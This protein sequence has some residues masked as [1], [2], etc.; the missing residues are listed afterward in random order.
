MT[1]NQCFTGVP[2]DDATGKDT[3]YCNLPAKQTD[4][5]SQSLIQFSANLATT[6]YETLGMANIIWWHE[7][8]PPPNKLTAFYIAACALFNLS[9]SKDRCVTPQQYQV[10]KQQV[11]N[12]VHVGGVNA[13]IIIPSKN[14]T[15]S[16]LLQ[17]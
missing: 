12:S 8:E 7:A 4:A 16:L 11:N 9:L 5:G 2:I 6:G 13:D 17:N 1:C 15:D 3:E 14:H 10:T